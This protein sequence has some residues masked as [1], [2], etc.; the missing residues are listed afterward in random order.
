MA[1]PTSEEPCC[2]VRKFVDK[3][4]SYR[5]EKLV[6]RA[7]IGLQFEP[8]SGQEIGVKLGPDSSQEHLRFRLAISL[9]SSIPGLLSLR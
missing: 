4:N 5:I 6:F 8:T 9:K 3:R 1:H 2:G 7:E